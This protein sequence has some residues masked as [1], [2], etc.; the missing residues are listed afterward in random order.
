MKHFQLRINT[1][2]ILSLLAPL[3]IIHGDNLVKANELY[4]Q[5]I[6]LMKEDHKKN[7]GKTL[8]LL[9]NAR[10]YFFKVGDLDAKSEATLMKLNSHI[11][12]QS[13]F[14]NSQQLAEAAS[15]KE[16]ESFG[17]SDK[18]K[19]KEKSLSPKI[20]DAF[21]KE[22]IAKN[23]VFDKK[24]QET[25]AFEEKHKNDAMSNML[26]YM[27]L[28]TKVV[29]IKSALDLLAKTKHYNAELIKEKEKTIQKYSSQI[30]NYDK[31]LNAKEYEYIYK[32]LVKIVRYSNATP[33]EK[34]ILKNYTMEVMA[35][36]SVK[37][38]LLLVGD[39]KAMPLPRQYTNFGGVVINIDTKGLKIVTED[40]T[41]GFLSWNVV[42]EQTILSLA[43]HV[44]DESQPNNLHLLALANLRLDNY[45]ESYGFFQ[46][47][48]EKDPKNYLKFRDYL[49]VCETGY[50]LKFGPRFEKIFEKVNRYRE[51]GH[52]RQAID[53]L[54]QLKEDYL[55]SELG[56]SYL[57][58]F[59][60]IYKD[61]LRS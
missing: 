2:L 27:D 25:K 31:L 14:S 9:K 42:S 41:P 37:K 4:Q 13:K 47:L 28:Q 12:W 48:I 10:E 8:A 5:A 51:Q 34:S 59:S 55:M 20:K 1:L 18:K 11:Y 60:M 49:S 22:K 57:E 54:I 56:Q 35:M 23:Q 45:E 19:N 44:I 26:N 52:K 58:R 46:K 39:S 15:L 3:G 53:L 43:L 38:K 61:V 30:K 40:R 17:G 29:D 36:A 21:E 16:D 33:N 24:L 7:A 6:T 50:R 32:E